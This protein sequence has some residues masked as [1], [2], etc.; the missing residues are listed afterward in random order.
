MPPTGRSNP[1]AL[2]VLTC[3][4]ERPM[5][6]YEIAQTL[7]SRAKHESIRLNY[8]SLYSVVNALEKRGLI[9]ARETVRDG[10][11]PERTIYEITDTGSR[12]LDRLA[13][14]PH[15]DTGE[16]IP[17]V[18]GGAVT[19]RRCSRS[20]TRSRCCASASPRSK[21]QRAQMQAVR[22]AASDA[23]LPRIFDIEGEYKQAVLEAELEYVRRLVKDI[24]SGELEGV[25]M[26]RTFH[27]EDREKKN[28]SE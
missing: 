15:L 14:R 20:T 4:Y 26:W 13:V 11:R 16:G 18:R 2:A 1:L 22:T 12:E 24:E 5:H 28:E 17:A 25:E 8:G 23:G 6:P 7:R 27:T 19:D 9:A 10:R 3:L 21:S